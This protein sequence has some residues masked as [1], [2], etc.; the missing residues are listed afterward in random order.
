MN[1]ALTLSSRSISTILQ[2]Y[3]RDDGKAFVA[4]FLA[5]AMFV[6]VGC[7]TVVSSQSLA[8]FDPN[9]SLDNSFLTAVALAFGIGIVVLAY[10]IAP[11]SG[12]HINPAVTFSFMLLGEIPVLKGMLYITSQLFGALLG[13]SILYGMTASNSLEEASGGAPAFLLG[14]NTVQPDLPLGSAFLGECV[15]TFILVW[16][17]MMTAVHKKNVAGNLAPLAIG[18]SVLLA[19]LLLVPFTGCGINPARSFGPHI[20][21]VFAGDKVGYEGWWIFYT[22]PFVGAAA[23]TFLSDFL[24]GVANEAE[25]TLIVDDAEDEVVEDC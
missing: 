12:A 19:H 16:T 20:V 21:V 10:S 5:M 1:S 3:T 25:E 18:L 22:A 7:G 15:G 4:E 24:F 9:T 11:I 14:S 2:V 6:I 8:A 23:A 13:A 17:V